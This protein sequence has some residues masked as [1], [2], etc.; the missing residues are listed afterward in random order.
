VHKAS[1]MPGEKFKR[2]VDRYLTGKDT[3]PW[4]TLYFKAY[5][6]NFL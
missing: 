1:T 5:K 4:E 2:D 3:E 6:N